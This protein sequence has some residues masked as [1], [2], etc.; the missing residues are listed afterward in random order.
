MPL[1]TAP[2]R[3]L[4]LLSLLLS[5]GAAAQAA[6]PAPPPAPATGAGAS[7][8][9][10][11]PATRVDDFKEVLHGVEIPDPYRW[12][13]D[14][15]SPETR[16]WIDAQN[17]YSHG[18][19]ESLPARGAIRRRLE[20][21]LSIDRI[22]MPMERGGRYLFERKGAHEEV[23]TL[24]QR[25]GREGRD[26][27]LIDPRTLAADGTASVETLDLS[28][29][30]KLLA[31]GIRHGGEDEVELRLKDLDTGKDLAERFPRGLYR[32]VVLLPDASGFYYNLQDRETG[33][34]TYYH[35]IGS[36]RAKDI[37][38]FGRGY[39]RDKW[40]G[41]MGA[42]G[43]GRYVLFVVNHGWGRT[44]M[45]LQDRTAG[46]PVKTLANDLDAHFN[47]QIAGDQLYAATVWQ[48][49][50][51]RIVAIDLKNPARE[52]WRELVPAG[53]DPIQGYALAGGKL[54]VHYLHDV[55]SR[56]A[57]FALDGKPLGELALPGI[58]SV[59]G[60]E[61]RWD[62]DELFFDFQ[63][64][65]V[66]PTVFRYSVAAGTAATWSSAAVPFKADP[67]EVKQVWYASKDG[68]RVP[69]FI[70]ARRGIALDGSH[71]T[72][73]Y[74]YG[75]F[76]ISLRPSF[77]AT[78]AWWL[79]QG[80]VYALANLRGGNELG[81]D[82]HRAGML[83]KK[84]NV[85]DDFIA[86][87]EQLIAGGYTN[88]AHLAIEG[89]SNGGLLVGGRSPSGRTSSRRS[90]AASPTSTWSA[91]TASRT[92]TRRPCWSMAT[93]PDLS[94]S[95]SSMPT[96]PIR[97]C[98]RGPATRR[99]SSSPATPTPACPPSRRAR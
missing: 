85:F 99:C 64:F 13:E 15:E 31:Y 50:N 81:E 1:P 21:L 28:Q 54:L 19:L 14:Q 56:V 48:A 20:E 74:G 67:Y 58:G 18:V 89:G 25:R 12:L 45:Y 16:R 88:P 59:S 5:T 6:P 82:W 42:S 92:T 4:A 62:G 11:P 94:S 95:S 61:G 37:E 97:R 32:G 91:T 3:V 27:V 24:Y 33:T 38:V 70:V 78:T 69:M 2:R 76:R 57:I 96:R 66:P 55:T 22:G 86:A 30:G 49:S 43:D 47:V 36:D 44:E 40:L 39:G 60:L 51:G 63:S 84:Q 26:E 23:W 79:E 98:S 53:P 35:A 34:L 65:T 9:T 17:A 83:E 41:A 80:G 29:D 87:A 93:P 73:L 8:T 90:S 71:P 72:R 68:T 75:G 7:P 46:G 52:K 10:G 77:S